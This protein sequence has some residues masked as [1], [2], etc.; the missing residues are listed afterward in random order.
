MMNNGVNVFGNNEISSNAGS[1]PTITSLSSTGEKIIKFTFPSTLFQ[2]EQFEDYDEQEFI[3]SLTYRLLND[4]Q[5]CDEQTQFEYCKVFEELFTRSVTELEKL[6]DTVN[7]RTSDLIASTEQHTANHQNALNNLNVELESVTEVFKNLEECINKVGNTTVQIGNTLESVDKQKKRA[8]EAKKLME[9]FEEF[10]KY[11]PLHFAGTVLP[12]K[13]LKYSLFHNKLYQHSV[14]RI[15]K[16]L[17]TIAKDLDKVKHCENGVA[18]IDYYY[19]ALLK[20]LSRNFFN[21]IEMLGKNRKASI[22]EMRMRV[23]I[24]FDLRENQRCID[25][26]VDSAFNK[27]LQVEY[28]SESDDYDQMYFDS[29]SSDSDLSESDEDDIS[30]SKGSNSDNEEDDKSSEKKK[31]KKKSTTNNKSAQKTKKQ[32]KKN[33]RNSESDE[34][35][36]NT[37]SE[38]KISDD[39]ETADSEKSETNVSHEN[40]EDEEHS[41]DNEKELDADTNSENEESKKADN[42]TKNVVEKLV[43]IPAESKEER[44]RKRIARNNEQYRLALDALSS[45]VKDVKDFESLLSKIEKTCRDEYTIVEQVF[46]DTVGKDVFA[47]LLQKLIEQIVSVIADKLLLDAAHSE[48][49][50]FLTTFEQIYTQSMAFVERLVQRSGNNDLP[51]TEAQAL[52]LL[53]PIFKTNRDAYSRYELKYLQAA[54]KEIM[55]EVKEEENRILERLAEKKQQKGFFKGWRQKA[56]LG[57]LLSALQNSD[58]KD[59]KE[60]FPD[61]SLLAVVQ[62]I[63]ENASA[64]GR[65]KKLTNK[66]DLPNNMFEIFKLLVNTIEEYVDRGLDFALSTVEVHDPKNPPMPYFFKALQLANS[67]LQNLQRHLEQ[68]IIPFVS[69]DFAVQLN[70]IKIKDSMFSRLEM[71]VAL[72]LELTLKSIFNHIEYILG[73]EQKKTDYHPKELSPL[74]NIYVDNSPSVACTKVCQFIEKQLDLI[75]ASLY[76]SNREF[77]LTEI[78]LKFY[79]VLTTS[80]KNYH[81][82]HTGAIRFMRDLSEYQRVMRKFEVSAVED[83]FDFLREIASLF[84]V[85]PE[86]IENVLSQL[87]RNRMN[88]EELLSFVKMRA[89][90]K[91]ELQKKNLL[92]DLPTSPGG[93]IVQ[94]FGKISSANN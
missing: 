4:T 70:C 39:S 38:S 2:I 91:T 56:D 29:K 16:Q 10:N 22:N 81:I 26:Y 75:L 34:Q 72:G 80:L 94:K 19:N 54:Y 25:L 67:I 46:D 84:L 28:E 86:N 37:N 40:S 27:F 44:E 8:M 60:E 64:I 53:E 57:A 85:A 13:K 15:M 88:R 6:M 76:G 12:K 45:S 92:S 24:L 1:S 61:L 3:E 30:D 62:L 90:Y 63:K 78:G 83:K 93:A 73:N 36:E 32:A 50:L 71:K 17:S 41:E 43:E 33:D 74:L 58:K 68:N 51:V 69:I 20:V 18:N 31:G 5:K 11:D 52:A 47:K 77:F 55:D 82:S 35:S 89:D 9:Y 59:S 21:A 23:K 66:K 65:C 79:Q 14:A 87:D 7:K 42:N 48:L 49:S